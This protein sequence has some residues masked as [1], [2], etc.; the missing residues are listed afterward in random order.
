MLLRNNLTGFSLSIL[1]LLIGTSLSR[2]APA[3]VL[4][5]YATATVTVPY[6]WQKPTM[7][8][9]IR[10]DQWRNAVSVNALQ[11]TDKRLSARQ[12]TF[13]MMWDENNIYIA[14]RS[15]LRPGERLIRAL[16]DRSH[17][18]N[19][20][21]DDSYEIWVDAG[22]H[23]PDGQPVFFQ[24]LSNFAAAR[25]DVMFEPAVG[26]SRIS[27]TA[28]WNP[29]NRLTENGSVWEMELTIPRSSIYKTSPFADGDAL[30]CLFARDYKRPWDQDNFGGSG[31]FAVQQ[32]YPKF[33]LSKS[34]P[35]LHLL[36]IGDP[37]TQKL[38]V[39][40]AGI[41][42]SDTTLD[43]SYS[44]DSG[45]QKSGVLH[46]A[47]G[48]LTTVEDASNIDT[49]GQ[50]GYRFTV[51]S[52]D[53]SKTYLDWAGPRQ[54]GDL[55]ALSQKFSDTGDQVVLSLDL[56]PVRHYIR[57]TGD[58]IDYDNRASITRY[59][60]DVN[61]SAGKLIA[62]KPLHLDSLAY[63]K[64][65]V[66]LPKLSAG[67]YTAVLTASDSAGKVV[68]TRQN[69]FT[70]RDPAAFPWWNTTA[71]NINRVISPW[72][73][74]E[75]GGG[76]F[77]VWGRTMSEGPVGLPSQITVLGTPLLT[78]AAILT[79][80]LQNG[81]TVTASGS[82]PTT[83]SSTSYRTVTKS[84]GVLGELGIETKTTVEFDGMYRVDLTITPHLPVRVE[85]LKLIVPLKSSLATYLHACA[86]GIRYGFDYGFLPPSKNG[87]LWNSQIIDGQPMLVGSFIPYI[88][89]GNDKNGL[90]WFADSDQG[91]NP[92]NSTPAI[93]IYRNP[94]GRT[95]DMVFNFIGKSAVIDKPR[96]ITF[97][98]EATPVKPM[99]PHWRMSTWWTGD[100]FKDWAQVE[101][102][103]HAGNEGLI[104]S[105][106]PFPLDPKA[107]K[108]MVD[109]RHSESNGGIFGFNKYRANAVPYFEH[110]EMGN[111]FVPE[112]GYFGDEWRTN[113]S[114]G[115]AYGK[116][117]QDFMVYNV[118]NWVKESGID[119][120]YIDNVAPIADDNV[121]AGRG[122]YLPDGLVQPAY[123]MFDTRTYLLRMRAAL[124]EQGKSGDF[125]L[126]ITNHMIAPWIGAADVALDGED[127]VIYPEMNKDFMDFWSLDRLRLDYPE[128]WG[129]SVNFLQEHQGNW[130]PV[131][132][133]TAMRAYT[134]MQLLDD[135]LASGNANGNNQSLW[136][137]RD[138]FGIEKDDVK[139]ISYW[140]KD[141]GLAT[142]THGV[143]I[144][145]WERPSGK[146][147]SDKLL[148]AV[149]NTGEAANAEVNVNFQ[150]FGLA[151]S[152]A[153]AN[154]AESQE[155]INLTRS[156]F[157][158]SI[159]RHDYRLIE[160]DPASALY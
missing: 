34:A 61:D 109:E 35:S 100:S 20:V 51:K 120:F 141:S 6:A 57:V 118:S 129:T 22:T 126:H 113:I 49:A 42:K 95:T 117:L 87:E 83:I 153:R 136:I 75:Y 99:E 59:L 98:F 133:K 159:P 11:S 145:A 48:Q 101:S 68:F 110:I 44:S 64:D 37:A 62:K 149:V 91:W 156:G 138:K 27:W 54:W 148:I 160:I 119:G 104:F 108:A 102:E 92:D 107:S 26:N 14:M 32:T 94:G 5:G 82:A 90:C 46:L 85:D 39:E 88:W 97:A 137:A 3:S 150:K 84:N 24:Y 38:G 56:N 146:F 127:H 125:V 89:V 143:Y 71:G 10:D 70:T 53:G 140:E 103:G 114:K 121:D 155:K 128:Q 1:A 154:D 152:T 9:V 8:G 106:I 78:G 111:Q 19:C 123:S 43:W 80:K 7:D 16:R 45:V 18:V 79:A 60:L 13:W 116:T 76:K 15:P 28:G 30:A 41:S 52:V 31:S 131:K 86:E 2:S 77:S 81:R 139:F 33:V 144:S 151:P 132:L 67:T 4:D 112:M 55:S 29:Q 115:L 23:S 69:T 135:T 96:T 65:V 21:F 63:V 25:Y 157:F 66:D 147:G 142:S 72:T 17:D 36:S 12:A 134:G 124:A 93:E 73:P 130:D 74:V 40:F 47:P 122:Y 50:G 158:T 58:L 105:S